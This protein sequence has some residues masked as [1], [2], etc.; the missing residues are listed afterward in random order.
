MSIDAKQSESNEG[1]GPM[2]F[3][4]DKQRDVQANPK[5]DDCLDHN[6]NHLEN[7]P[8]DDSRLNPSEEAKQIEENE[9]N[10]IPPSGEISPQTK[11]GMASSLI[12]NPMETS[13][14]KHQ[15]CNYLNLYFQNIQLAVVTCLKLNN[16]NFPNT[17]HLIIWVEH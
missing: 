6:N 8:L 9:G 13:T 16:Q 5:S 14:M 1:K 7:L 17:K 11:D 10:Q 2:V 15:V 12:H 4:T 3:N